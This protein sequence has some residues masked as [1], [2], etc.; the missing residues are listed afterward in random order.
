MNRCARALLR[1]AVGTLQNAGVP[2]AAFDARQLLLHVCGWDQ[3]EWLLRQ[4]DPLPAETETAYG[5]A[6]S[7]RASGEPLQ[8]IIGSWPFY[9]RA[10]FV[11]PGVLIPRPET[12]ELTDLCVREIVSRGKT[13]V[14]DLCAG[15]GCIGVS[16]AAACPDADVWLFELSED[17]LTYL[18]K[19]VPA[20]AARRIHVIRHDI[21][22]DCPANLPPPDLIV[23]NPPYIPDGELPGLQREVRREPASAL[24]GGADGLDFYRRITAGWLGLLT[25][26]G[27]AAFE[28]GEGQADAIVSMI[29]RDL[30]PGILHDFRGAARFVVCGAFTQAKKGN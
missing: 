18:Q 7:R 2:D 21:F 29:P 1:D 4:D 9:G 22:E 16:I 20:Q 30:S 27:C 28:C 17:A 10:F 12:E 19:N 6:V 13:T 24:A 5:L 23:S 8:Y 3:S 26:N 25:E 11:G 15:S 14:Y